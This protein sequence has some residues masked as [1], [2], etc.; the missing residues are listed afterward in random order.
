[1]DI[2]FFPIV[3]LIILLIVEYKYRKPEEP[4]DLVTL[5]DSAFNKRFDVYS[6]SETEARY[7]VTPLFMELLN[8][9]QTAFGSKKLKCSFFN[10]FGK[11][12]FMVAI[13]T[14]K[15]LFE[16]GD[17]STP[18]DNPK[19]ITQFYKELKSIYAMIEYFKLD[20]K[21]NKITQ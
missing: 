5:E 17:I 2:A 20:K 7:L 18:F 11:N 9:L 12:R 16:I 1:M 6:S 13:S 4:L 10:Y 15:D 8:N 14:K 21:Y 19:H 3:V